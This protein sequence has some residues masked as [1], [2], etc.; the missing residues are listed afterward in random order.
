MADY[1]AAVVKAVQQMIAHKGASNSGVTTA[2][3]KGKTR[4]LPDQ[5]DALREWLSKQ[6][7]TLKLHTWDNASS[8]G[9]PVH[10]SGA[11]WKS[12]EE[13]WLQPILDD[14]R[15]VKRDVKRLKSE[16]FTDEALSSLLSE[17]LG[18]AAEV[19]GDVI[20]H[21]NVSINGTLKATSLETRG[22]DY[23]ERFAKADPSEA[24]EAGAVVGIFDDAKVAEGVIRLRTEGAIRLGIVSTMPSVCGAV[25][26]TAKDTVAVCVADW[27]G[28]LPVLIRGPVKPGDSLVAS[29]CNDGM[30]MAI[31]GEDVNSIGIALSAPV[32]GRVTILTGS[33]KRAVDMHRAPP[34]SPLSD[35]AGSWDLCDASTCADEATNIYDDTGRS[36]TGRS[37]ASLTELKQAIEGGMGGGG[38][39]GDMAATLMVMQEQVGMPSSPPRLLSLHLSVYLSLSP[40]HLI[41]PHSPRPLRRGR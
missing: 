5:V 22:A 10:N 14:Q 28:R 8:I 9:L 18:E 37:D 19:K 33:A 16:A 3:R 12:F 35:S 34:H 38:G 24:I 20:F 40:H 17:E 27:P 1:S 13:K 26:D 4:A 36:E 25:T 23:T 39:M 29:G 31:K 11:D 21:G 6:H 7:P 30:A 41:S 32:D 2:A 15:S